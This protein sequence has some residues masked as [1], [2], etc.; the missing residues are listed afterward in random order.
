[1]EHDARSV[2]NELLRRA[3]DDGEPVT[4]LKIMKL[5]YFCHAWMLGLY[6][7]P[8]QVQPIEAWR[9]GPVVRDVYRSLRRYGSEPI[10]HPIGVEPEEYSSTQMDLIDQVWEV[11]GK[12]TARQLSAMTHAPGT[13][14]HHIWHQW[15][16]SAVIP[17]PMIEEYYSDLY[18]QTT[19][20]S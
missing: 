1:M 17:D 19:R 10:N 7:E 3:K 13:P 2:A 18:D 16:E 15:G 11:Y 9:F 12:Y 6:H 5:V 20:R 8:L 14:W 4:H